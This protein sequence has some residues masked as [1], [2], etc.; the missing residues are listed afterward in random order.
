MTT[1]HYPVPR[2]PAPVRLK[3]HQ[4][5]MN[6]FITIVTAGFWLP[7]WALITWDINRQNRR[8]LERFS[9]ELTA[10]NLAIA[11]MTNA[12]LPR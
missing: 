11:A 7:F 1:T 3:R 5:N 4:H 6:L 12:Q 2:Y 9:R 10:Y 8:E